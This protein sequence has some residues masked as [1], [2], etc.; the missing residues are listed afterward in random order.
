M[1]IVSFNNYPKFQIDFNSGLP[2]T[3]RFVRP[4]PFFF[5][6]SSI[7]DTLGQLLFYTNGY[8]IA[9]ASHDTLL[10]SKNFNPGDETNDG[11]LEGNAT[12]QGTLIIP[13]PQSNSLY[14]IFHESG[15]YFNAHGQAQAQPLN[16]S[17]SQVDMNLDNGLGGITASKKDIHLINDTLVHGRIAACKHANGRDWW[18]VVAR[19]YSNTYY[20]ILVTPDT[21]Y[22]PYSIQSIGDTIDYDAL[23]QAV[24]SPDGNKYAMIGQNSNVEYFR[25]DRCSGDFTS[26]SKR[27]TRNF[28]S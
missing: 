15:K 10:N 16:L 6:N 8:Y 24:F 14:Y 9:N 25:F 4:M 7:C 3:L 13:K 17:Y 28:A 23:G 22:S 11:Y 27:F 1:G 21:I 20:K 12:P 18:I 19:Y 2:D 5:T 26:S